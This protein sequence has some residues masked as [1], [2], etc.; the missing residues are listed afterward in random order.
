MR[1]EIRKTG[2]RPRDGYSEAVATISKR[3]KSSEKQSAIAAKFPTYAEFEALCKHRASA[4]IPVPNPLNIPDELRTT[5][6]GKTV[7]A[8][9]VNAQERFLLYTGQDGK[10]LNF[11][12]D[13]EL[14]TLSQ[15]PF[16]VCDGTF[17]MAPNSA[18]QLYTVHGYLNGEGLPLVWAL[19]PNKSKATSVCFQRSVKVY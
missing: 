1:N 17:E 2:K 3:F 11:C 18:Y 14:T 8:D 9:D 7:E 13:T 19:L 12:S 10:L 6:R 5:G 15:S 16:I 4:L